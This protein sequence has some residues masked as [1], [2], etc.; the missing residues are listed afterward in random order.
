MPKLCKR[1]RHATHHPNLAPAHR[2]ASPGM[3]RKAAQAAKAFMACALLFLAVAPAHASGQHRYGRDSGLGALR[4]NQTTA[5]A[6]PAP[7]QERPPAVETLQARAD[8]WLANQSL[9]LAAH[10]PVAEWDTSA[11][12]D[13]ARVFQGAADFNE[14]IGCWDVARAETMQGMYVAARVR[15]ALGSATRA[16]PARPLTHSPV[17]C[18]CLVQ[19]R[20]GRCLQPRH[21]PLGRGACGGHFI[22]VRHRVDT[23]AALG[24]ALTPH[25]LG[26]HA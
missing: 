7:P 21:R 12:T 9:A 11:E 16:P 20:R 10:G 14:G 15:R 4:G 25:A 8:A 13:L 18:T 6:A 5:A 2:T 3:T 1:R 24:H 26:G 22:S 17:C 23:I 19:V